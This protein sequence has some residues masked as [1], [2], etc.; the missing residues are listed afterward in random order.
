MMKRRDFITLLGGAAAAWPLAARAQQRERM[1]RIGVLLPATANDAQYQARVGAFLQA[2]ALLGWTIGRNVQVDTRWATANVAEVRR[3][4]AEL[5]ALAP[6]VILAHGGGPVAAVQQATHTVPIVFPIAGDP[7]GS[8]LVD[9]LA[10][11]GGN[12]TGFLEFEYSIGGK[13]LELL[14]EIA[15][16]VNRAAVLRDTTLGTGAGQFA[17][18]QAVAPLLRM[19]VIPVNVQKAAEIERAIA[20]FARSSNGGQIVTGGGATQLHRDLIITLAARHKLPAV[21]NERTFV[22]GGGLISYGPDY[23]DQYRLAAGYVDRILKGEKPADLPVQ[24]PTKYELVINLK[25]AK[26][27]GLEIPSS[28]L[29]RADEVIE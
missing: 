19:E 29:A 25:T 5:V 15:P 18:I 26:A 22:A 24:A 3:H 16:S 1:R 10:R 12:A 14:K 27:L 28:V 17:A 7:V 2:L 11:P 23:L 13:W 21:Y 4:A 6:D 8:G 20:T 9:S